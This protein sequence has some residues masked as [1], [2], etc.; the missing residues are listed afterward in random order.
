[1]I[2][3]RFC[4][5]VGTPKQHAFACRLASRAGYS[6]LR[7]AVADALGISA[8]KAGRRVI[9]IKDA[10]AIIEFLLKKTREEAEQ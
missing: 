8:S 4:A 9:T 7:Y 2:D 3:E 1:M 10:S 6:A 5:Q